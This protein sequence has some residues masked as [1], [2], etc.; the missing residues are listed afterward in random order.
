[1]VHRLKS[2][3]LLAA[4]LGLLLML[5][6]GASA[7]QAAET[8][9]ELRLLVR[10]G[11][12]VRVQDGEGRETVGRFVSVSPERLR[13]RVKGQ[14]L[15]MAPDAVAQVRKRQ[16]DPLTNGAWIGAG[17]GGAW[18]GTVWLVC[19]RPA[20]TARDGDGDGVVPGGESTGGSA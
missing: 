2:S 10:P 1:M 19:R 20:A 11:E 17:V 13:I 7:Q 15:D 9:S 8:L 4:G 14:V 12:K 3:R 18:G 5:P 16:H 6:A